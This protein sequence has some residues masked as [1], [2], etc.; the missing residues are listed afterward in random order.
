MLGEKQ[1]EAYVGDASGLGSLSSASAAKGLALQSLATV[2]HMMQQGAPLVVK[3]PRMAP[4]VLQL[5]VRALGR[6]RKRGVWNQ[7]VGQLRMECA[8]PPTRRCVDGQ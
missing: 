8:L 1:Y 5:Y 4:R 3:G 7:K 2:P 6:S